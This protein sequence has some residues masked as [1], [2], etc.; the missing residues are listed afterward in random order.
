[1]SSTAA[2]PH[3]RLLRTL[4]SPQTVLLFAL[5]WGVFVMA[6]RVPY[7]TD[8]W[9]HVRLGQEMIDNQRFAGVD[10][11]S[12]TAFGQPMNDHGWLGEVIIAGVYGLWGASGLSFLVALVVA[13]TAW[14]VYGSTR[15]SPAVRVFATLLAM[16]VSSVVWAPRP[17]VFSLLMLAAFV[18]VLAT[19]RQG[20]SSRRLWALPFL[21][22][23]W[24]NLHAAFAA[25]FIMMG[26]FAAADAISLPFTP[27][28]Q[29]R[30][31]ARRA[32]LVAGVLLV[33]VLI[34]PLAPKGLRMYLYPFET[35]S[36]PTLQAYIQEWAS[37][38]FHQLFQQPFI[39][40][41]LLLLLAIGLSPGTADWADLG[42]IVLFAYMAL[43]ARRNIALFALATAPAMMRYVQSAWE[44][45]AGR[46][47]AARGKTAERGRK[48]RPALAAAVNGILIVFLVLVGVVK[49]GVALSPRAQAAQEAALFPM[50]A[51]EF[52]K[53]ETAYPE[54]FNHYNWGGYLTWALYPKYRVFVDGRTDLYGGGV[55]EDYIGAYTA[56]GDWQG[57]LDKWNVRAVLVEPASPLAGLL[58]VHEGWRLAYEDEQAVVFFR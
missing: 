45:L 41:L 22:I 3:G 12:H 27:R 15:A 47:K 6:V 56:P 28:E 32:V 7:D 24:V 50:G 20:A 54:L 55:L 42:V 14:L 13:A 19:H 48:L 18:W 37:P 49:I 46:W 23:L 30:A 10:L 5:F 43:W 40:Q 53:S 29:R 2:R 39:W 57:I 16:V 4:A 31:L 58:R 38:D 1:M 36:I 26:V 21:T 34:V 35:V 11:Y 52:L 25:G 44:H 33:C 8:M 9:W 17:Q 51:V